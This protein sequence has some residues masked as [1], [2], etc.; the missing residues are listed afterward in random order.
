MYI[1]VMYQNGKTGVVETYQLAE[2]I[3]SHKIKKFIRSEGWVT[4]G[5]DPIRG[6]KK[7]V[8]VPKEGKTSGEQDRYFWNSNPGDTMKDGRHHK[9]FIV[10]TMDIYGKMMF[11]HTVKILN[12]SVSGVLIKADRRLNIGRS[13]VLKM[14]DKGEVLTV[15]GTVIHSILSES[16]RDPKCNI[17]PIY[18]AGMKFTKI[19]NKEK[20]NEIINLV[21]ES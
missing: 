21:K 20:I 7:A 18:T 13:Y 2:H 15:K 1:T 14:G 5:V 9:R 12:I 11:F 19:L 4:V 16:Y 10:D 3:H 8:K 17:V 6:I